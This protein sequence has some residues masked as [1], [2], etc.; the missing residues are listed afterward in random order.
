MSCRRIAV[1]K[2]SE[3]TSSLGP[4]HTGCPQLPAPT[5]QKT[6]PPKLGWRS[7]RRGRERARQ[8][9]VPTGWRYPREARATQQSPLVPSRLSAEKGRP[10]RRFLGVCHL[11]L[12]LEPLSPGTVQP[13]PLSYGASPSLPAPLTTCYPHPTPYLSAKSDSARATNW[14]CLDQEIM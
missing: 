2:I 3:D 9:R 10:R 6:G 5:R 12:T 13:P 8:P 7:D 4:S 1:R 14:P 11:C